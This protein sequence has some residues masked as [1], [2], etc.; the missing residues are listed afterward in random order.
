LRVKL[1]QQF[2]QLS[3][4]LIAFLA[5]VTVTAAAPAEGV[6]KTAVVSF[7]LSGEQDVFRSEATGAASIVAR[8]FGADPV[9]VRF[10]TR[11]KG[12]ATVEALAA[13]LETTGKRIEPSTDVLFLILTSHGSRDGLEVTAGRRSTTLTPSKLTEML[14]R[15]GVRYKVVIISAC[16]SGVFIPRLATA[17]TL[18]ITAADANHP[19]FGCEDRAKWTYFGDAFFNAAL[20][21]S[22]TIRDAFMV[23]RSLILRREQSN[24]FEPSHPQMTGGENVEPLLIPRR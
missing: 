8:R 1:K 23:A 6:R 4:L 18:V 20:R 3:T 16:Y 17:D 12:D 19:S 10:N 21:Q 7:G 11:K 22:P 14:D 24:G 15:T 5:L 13:T 2:K 9:I